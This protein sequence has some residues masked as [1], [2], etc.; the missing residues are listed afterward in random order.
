MY[1]SHIR[2]WKAT[3][4]LRLDKLNSTPDLLAS[5]LLILVDVIRL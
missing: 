3:N 2:S 1:A 5:A 4:G